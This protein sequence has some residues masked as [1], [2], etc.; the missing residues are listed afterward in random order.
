MHLSRSL[1]TEFRDTHKKKFGEEISEGE[2]RKD[3][4]SLANTV[5]ILI[6]RRKEKNE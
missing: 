1:V 3:L 6:G 5:K 2:A 4:S